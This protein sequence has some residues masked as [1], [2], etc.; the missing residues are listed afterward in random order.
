MKMKFGWRRRRQRGPRVREP[1]AVEGLGNALVC[2]WERTSW[3]LDLR[4]EE[5][6]HE[7]EVSRFPRSPPGTGTCFLGQDEAKEELC[8]APEPR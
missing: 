5:C 8:D 3:L 6:Q 7:D 4:E 2:D 1:V